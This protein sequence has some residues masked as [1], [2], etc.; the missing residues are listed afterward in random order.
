[1]TMSYHANSEERRRLTTG[2]RE[3]ADFL[4]HN[5]QIPAPRRADLLV[6]PPDGSDAEMFA[7]VDVIAQ[8]IGVTASRGEGPASHYSASRDFGPVQYR[9]VAIPHVARRH[10]EG[11]E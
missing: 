1:M 7:E 4:D 9:A 2:L 3:L 10:G 8:Q 11:A 5:P 6:F